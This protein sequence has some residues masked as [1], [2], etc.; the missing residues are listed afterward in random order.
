MNL[1]TRK[2]LDEATC[3]S[4]GCTHQDHGPLHLHSRCHPSAGT[5]VAYAQGILTIRCRKCEAF[6]AQVL[7]AEDHRLSR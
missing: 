7:V 4:P 6:I 5:R 1:L 3:Q 2:E